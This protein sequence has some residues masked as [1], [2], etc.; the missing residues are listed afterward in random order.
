MISK[1]TEIMTV[2]AGSFGAEM[3]AATISFWAQLFKED[4]ITIN[5]IKAAAK[6]IIRTRKFKSM[7]TYAEFIEFCSGTMEDKARIQADLV[8]TRVKRYGSQIKIKFND[9]I[10]AHLMSVV[11]PWMSFCSSH[12]EKNTPFFVRDFIQ[13]Y[14]TY[15]K[16]FK[17]KQVEQIG[18]SSKMK[19]LITNI[20]NEKKETVEGE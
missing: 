5:Q 2:V 12:M 13:A 11:W 4:G 14:Q 17:I 15:Q 6:D 20:G 8:V 16:D 10:T 3:D 1:Y 7:P 19:K 18:C 9:P